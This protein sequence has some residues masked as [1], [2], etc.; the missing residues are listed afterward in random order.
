MEAPPN[1]R[2]KDRR[3]KTWLTVA[4]GRRVSMRRLQT[5]I[6]QEE[7]GRRYYAIRGNTS[8]INPQ[9]LIFQLENGERL[10]KLDTMMIVAKAM[11]LSLNQ[12]LGSEIV[13][14]SKTSGD[15]RVD[16]PAEA[17]EASRGES[18]EKAEHELQSRD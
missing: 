1:K 16:A 12:L 5:G 4:F 15:S 17:A 6:S 13:Q 8:V 11:G 10:P 2:G 7:L 9:S 14:W 3:N 18:G